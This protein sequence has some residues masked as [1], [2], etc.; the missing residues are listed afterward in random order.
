M[1]QKVRHFLGPLQ[2]LTSRL[3]T[4]F[5]DLKR[6]FSQRIILLIRFYLTYFQD[7]IKAFINFTKNGKIMIESWLSSAS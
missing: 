4:Y 2:F 3:F 1:P 5:N 6:H 7:H